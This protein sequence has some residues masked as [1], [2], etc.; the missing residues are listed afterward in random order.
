[1]KKTAIILAAALALTSCSLDEKLRSSSETEDFYKNAVQCRTGINACYNLLRTIFSGHSVWLMTDA[2]TDC[3]ILNASTNYVATLNISPTRPA[4]AS[5]IWQYGY[6]GVM[7]ANGMLEAV[8]N[9]RR[10]GGCTDSEALQMSG[11]LVAVRAMFYYLLTCTFGDV[12][13][14]TVSVNENNRAEIASL[15]RMSA[16]DTRD[17]LIDELLHYFLPASQGGLEALPLKRSYDPPFE[18]RLNAPVGL[19]LAAKMCL[20]NHR[21]EDA[22]T[23]LEVLEDIYGDYTS[24][25]EAFG[26]DYPMTDIPFSQK[27]TSE[28]ILEFGNVFEEYGNQST[29]Y[30]AVVA[31]PSKSSVVAEGDESE[32]AVSDVYAGIG[33]PELGT[34]S[35]I[36]VSCRPTTWFFQTVLSYDSP[37]LRSGEYSAGAEQARGGSGNLAWRWKGYDREDEQRLPENCTVRWFKT[38]SSLTAS[39]LA[40]I[41]RPWLGNKFWC[42]EMYYTMDSNNP[43][44]FRYADAL[45]MLS[46]AWLNLGDYDRAA[47]YLNITR[48]RAGLGKMSLQAVGGNPEAF[49]EEIRMERARELFG[50]FQRKFD[51]VRWGIWYERTSA[52]NDG[53][54]LKDFIR[55][56]HRYMPIP[57]EQIT[58]SSGALDNKEYGGN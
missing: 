32:Y 36:S 44:F 46:E 53:T 40:A 37:D 1:M 15:P 11:E 31:T 23:A 2:Q 3:M 41:N 17:Y 30:I 29:G 9:C 13:F 58:Y 26:V 24:A 57:A 34:Q 56:Y 5:T 18:N 50:E 35:R 48:T 42:P 4:I 33:I 25:P 21:W 8:E 14:Y 10:A 6:Q 47:S 52:Y 38:G 22:V 43:K 49:M 45:L 27:Y 19:M 7:R 12:P 54:Y 39:N 55:P 28:S 51:L 20:W 16:D